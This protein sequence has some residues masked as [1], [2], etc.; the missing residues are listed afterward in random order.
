MCV[1]VNHVLLSAALDGLRSFLGFCLRKKVFHINVPDVSGPWHQQ[2]R[3]INVSVSLSLDTTKDTQT[4]IPL[5]DVTIIQDHPSGQ[6]AFKLV[7]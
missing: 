5:L 1:Y 3:T 2:H 4:V 7:A 6:A